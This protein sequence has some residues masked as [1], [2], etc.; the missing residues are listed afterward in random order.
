MK[1]GDGRLEDLE[2]RRPIGGSRRGGPSDG[3]TSEFKDFDD[4]LRHEVSQAEVET[5][6][7]NESEHDRRCLSDLPA[8]GPLHAL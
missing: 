4:F 1:D 3:G 6:D 8:V 5:G 7:R 2:G